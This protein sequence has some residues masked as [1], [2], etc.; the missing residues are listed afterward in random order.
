MYMILIKCFLQ[1]G[2]ADC[3][4]DIVSECDWGI[5]SILDMEKATVHSNVHGGNSSILTLEHTFISLF[6]FLFDTG[7]ILHAANFHQWKTK[8]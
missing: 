7:S 4:D 6:K 3:I 1:P 5:E 2:D 8:V